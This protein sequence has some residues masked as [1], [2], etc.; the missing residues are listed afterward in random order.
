MFDLLIP[1]PL[2]EGFLLGISLI[3]AI[4]A[5]NLFVMR[6]GIKGEHVFTTALVSS[7]S[8]FAM[9]AVG[10]LGAGS[11]ISSIPALQ[12]IAVFCGIVFLTYY[13]CK[14]CM[15]LIQGRSLELVM[16][17]D[18]TAASRKTV[19]LGALG[20]SLLNPHAVLDGVVLIGGLSAQYEIAADRA[21]F[22]S[23]A[24]LAS[25]LWFFCLGYGAK[26][27]GPLFSKPAFAKGLD[28]FVAGIMFGIA[29]NLAKTEFFT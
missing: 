7:F 25:I 8:D 9:I 19:V 6:Q 4:G 27:A 5:Q 2:L 17:S 14:S 18:G 24:G 16:A 28:V 20:V 23:G 21:I 3:A 11:L 10:A 26:L 12:K 1:Q 22:A 15:S 13:G 29:W